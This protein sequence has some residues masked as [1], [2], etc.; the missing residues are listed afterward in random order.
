MFDEGLICL[1]EE[2]YF[3]FFFLCWE[4]CIFLV[5]V[6]FFFMKVIRDF[7]KFLFVFK[8]DICFCIVRDDIY[9]V[10]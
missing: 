7:I 1:G 8:C 2:S 10:K 3:L 9:W 4:E 5:G 6:F